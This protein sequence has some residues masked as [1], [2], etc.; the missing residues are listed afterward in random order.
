[1]GGWG[2]QS[3]RFALNSAKPV[4][5]IADS[6]PWPVAGNIEY[7]G[8]T[9]AIDGE[10]EALESFAYRGKLQAST[11]NINTLGAL[12]GLPDLP[13][14]TLD[15]TTHLVANNKQQSL[16]DLSLK[17]GASAFSGQLERVVAKNR[18]RYTGSLN[19]T[20]ADPGVLHQLVSDAS[21]DRWLP[22]DVDAEVTLRVDQLL[23]TAKTLS[24][25]GLADIELHASLNASKLTLAPLSFVFE[26]KPV[27]GSLNI[28]E[29]VTPPRLS[30]QLDIPG[31]DTSSLA[32]LGFA[33]PGLTLN[34]GPIKVDARIQGRATAEMVKHLTL[35]VQATDTSVVYAGEP[36]NT[37]VKAL[38]FTI[39]TAPGQPL[40]LQA[41]GVHE[42]FPLKL[43]ISIDSLEALYA[44]H[45]VSVA[46]TARSSHASVAIAGTITSPQELD[47]VRL[48]IESEGT[49]FE[50]LHPSL[51]LPWEQTG[52]FRF[53]TDLE[54]ANHQLTL[55][56]LDAEVAGNESERHGCYADR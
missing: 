54:H 56:N 8:V 38:D 4:A 47:G 15:L 3:I 22:V 11:T 17:L 23:G 55:H 6:A 46:A 16:S 24:E 12:L 39:S 43:E 19:A 42:N 50:I 51:W 32:H 1:M 29:S 37:A 5:S 2:Q 41:E 28:D 7:A 26:G 27:S 53:N 33:R 44:N 31:L 40:V 34:S 48:R 36:L 49:R 10:L 13:V 35:H 25:I 14:T 18:I 30:T 52:G 21:S 20:T 9:L 45:P